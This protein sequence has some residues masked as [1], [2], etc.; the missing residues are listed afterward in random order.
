[1]Q[2][3]PALYVAIAAVG[4]LL[5]NLLLNFQLSIRIEAIGLAGNPLVYK[6]NLLFLSGISTYPLQRTLCRS[7]NQV[8]LYPTLPCRLLNL[9]RP[10]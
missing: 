10:Q 3:Q 4:L 6:S 9:F 7:V 2:K 5:A 8:G 1:M